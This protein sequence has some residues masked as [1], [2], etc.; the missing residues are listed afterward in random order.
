MNG[1]VHGPENPVGHHVEFLHYPVLLCSCCIFCQVLGG[2]N[3]HGPASSPSECH[4]SKKEHHM[5]IWGLDVWQVCFLIFWNDFV[6]SMEGGE[7][8]WDV[9]SLNLFRSTGAWFHVWLPVQGWLESLQFLH[10]VMFEVPSSTVRVYTC[11]CWAIQCLPLPLGP[12]GDCMSIC[13]HR[14]WS[15]IGSHSHQDRGDER[16]LLALMC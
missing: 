4:V 15:W 12:N 2:V 11:H 8:S 7:W 13:L 3:Y 10:T 1:W 6:S 9:H 14:H 5:P 16:V